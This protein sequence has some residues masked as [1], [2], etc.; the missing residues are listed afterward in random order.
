MF[1]AYQ[2]GRASSKLAEQC[3]Q[4]V[5]GAMLCETFVSL[6]ESAALRS[7]SNLLT[8]PAT[9]NHTPL[10]LLSPLFPSTALGLNPTPQCSS[11]TLHRPSLALPTSMATELL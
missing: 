10:S 7:N 8:R 3:E 5:T 4:A 2:V 11:V 6:A 9:I 1:V